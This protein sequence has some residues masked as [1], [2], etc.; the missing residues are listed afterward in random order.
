MSDT[1]R[2][3]ES[4]VCEPV[5][6]FDGVAA[7]SKGDILLT[8][9]E[10]PARVERVRQVGVWAEALADGLEGDFAAAQFLLPS[11][12][13]PDGPARA[14]AK[15]TLDKIGPRARV[16]ATVPLGG[17]LWQR[18]VR[19]IIRAAVLIT[20]WS[21]VVKVP[22]SHADALR[23]LA[24]VATERTPPL[25]ELEAGIDA[26]QSALGAGPEAVRLGAARLGG[27]DVA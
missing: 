23:L 14:E 7:W 27:E 1:L 20:G 25:N 24:S 11:A 21:K 10:K 9:W 13:P 3:N 8:L 2:E 5:S 16:L 12:K 17:G 22:A 26:L 6:V 19:T 18:V 4:A 15:R